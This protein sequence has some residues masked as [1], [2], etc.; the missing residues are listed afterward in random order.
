[1]MARN[2][3]GDLRRAR[4]VAILRLHHHDHVV[5]IA[6]TLVEA[7]VEFLEVTVERST[8]LRGLAEVV[9]A[10][11]GQ[12]H[13]GAGTVLRES[14][15]TAVADA[16]ATFVVMPD[17][18]PAVIGAAKERGLFT[19]PG[20]FTPT[21]VAR[22]V[23]AGA[24]Y[25]KLFPASTGGIDHLRA[26]RGPFPQVAFIPTGGVSS[27]NANQWFAAGAVGV[28]MGTNLVPSSGSL[29]GLLERA[30]AAVRATAL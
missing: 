26:L 16:G 21:E 11:G 1:M 27:E 23:E 8:G 12:I 18:N 29:E 10:V 30:S 14:D 4:L 28:A 5:A 20:A 7:G 22:A 15:V 17:T 24:D 9:A 25:V 6:Q 2:F 19:L 3:D 13:V